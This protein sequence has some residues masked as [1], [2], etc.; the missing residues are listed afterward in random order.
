MKIKNRFKVLQ[1]KLKNSELV[2]MILI[3]QVTY[4]INLEIAAI[5]LIRQ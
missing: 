3:A 1:N 4:F 5:H 2:A